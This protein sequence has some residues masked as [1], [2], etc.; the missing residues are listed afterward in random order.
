MKVREPLFN[1]NCVC[2]FVCAC[3]WL[4]VCTVFKRFQA[5]SGS[6]VIASADDAEV[7]QT[8]TSDLRSCLHGNSLID[9]SV[10]FCV[11]RWLLIYSL[12]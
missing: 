11:V 9:V 1:L 7:S 12:L 8:L 10:I 2:V 5:V 3:V 6:D 4:C